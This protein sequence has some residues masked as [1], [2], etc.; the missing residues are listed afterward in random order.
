MKN[1]ILVCS[2][3]GKGNEYTQEELDAVFP[4]SRERL[5][6]KFCFHSL[7]VCSGFWEDKK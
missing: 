3:C 5:I 4:N 2:N 7:S 1:I 6:C